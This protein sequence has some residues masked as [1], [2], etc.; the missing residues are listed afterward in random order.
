M[1]Y[2]GIVRTRKKE[3]ERKKGKRKERRKERN[4]PDFSIPLN[5]KSEKTIT[6]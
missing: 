4:T 2:L 3:R 5:Q 6:N 1:N